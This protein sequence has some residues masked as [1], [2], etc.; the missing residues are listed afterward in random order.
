MSAKTRLHNPGQFEQVI[1]YA[2][3]VLAGGES[4]VVAPDAFTDQL[5][6]RG[7]IL[8]ATPEP[9]P[10]RGRIKPPKPTNADGETK[11]NAS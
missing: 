6:E 3:H 1:D 5:I 10:I 2:G 7:V 8:A 9:S 4:R 11:G